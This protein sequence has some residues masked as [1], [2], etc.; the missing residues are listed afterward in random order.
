MEYSNGCTE[1]WSL[2]HWKLKNSTALLANKNGQIPNYD[3]SGCRDG[4]QY[5][6]EKP[7]L[8]PSLNR[9]KNPELSLCQHRHL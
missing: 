1:I 9:V 3:C 4:K 7:V 5:L 8:K 6:F 2:E